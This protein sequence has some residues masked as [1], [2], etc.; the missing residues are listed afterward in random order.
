M[1]KTAAY[2]PADLN[3]LA[4][5]SGMVLATIESLSDAEMAAP[6]LA[7]G[8]SRAD[9]VAHLVGNARALSRLVDWAVTGKEQAMY[10][11]MEARNA[12]IAELAALPPAELKKTLREATAAFAATADQLRSGKLATEEV[13]MA[14]GPVNAYLLPAYRI[15]EIIVHHYDL[16]TVWTIEEADIDALED[17]LELAVDRISK[18]DD[19]PALSIETDEGESY[20][21]GSGGPTL[22]GGRDAVLGWIT[23]GTTDGL[24][25]DGELPERPDFA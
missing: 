20:A 21:I 19:Y 17:A 24:R 12:E 3:R 8:W 5:E 6:S 1:K 14:S 25:V 18:R 2:M 7:E 15:S 16:D 13:A 4:R 22:K 23:R 9:V 10:S 11:S